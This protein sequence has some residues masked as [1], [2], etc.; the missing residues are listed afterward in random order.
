MSRTLRSLALLALTTSPS[1]AQDPPKPATQ[2]KK[3]ALA[4][5]GE[6]AFRWI[7]RD[8]KEGITDSRKHRT[9]C[10]SCPADHDGFAHKQ[11]VG[12]ADH[13]VGIKQGSGIRTRYTI[14]LTLDTDGVQKLA[15]AATR[16]ETFSLGVFVD[17]KF[18]GV[19]AREETAK[20]PL[21]IQ[22]PTA[23][24][25]ARLYNAAGGPKLNPPTVVGRFRFD[26][27][28]DSSG[29]NAEV[30]AKKAAL[31]DG[32][33]YV[34]GKFGKATFRDQTGPYSIRAPEMKSDRFT[35]AMRFQA[36]RIR[37]P[38][39]HTILSGGARRRW[40]RLSNS[41]DGQLQI[42]VNGGSRTYK[43]DFKLKSKQWYSV[44]CQFD[45]AANALV[46]Q[47]DGK[48]LDGI[49]LPNGGIRIAAQEDRVWT[50]A[51]TSGSGSVFHGLVDE[52]VIYDGTF[53]PGNV[54]TDLLSPPDAK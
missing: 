23:A 48:Q 45:L 18:T 30:K 54:P 22:L 39:Y 14:E 19:M 12:V 34:N 32:S 53:W 27:L 11:A 6:I 33:L 49:K 16:A 41:R 25:V 20:Q 31:R 42:S 50:F 35:I 40:F 52:L 29:Q 24:E 13:I 46:V 47:V 17:G 1:L 2:A 5:A 8:H 9:I 15:Q 10:P 51:S 44:V 3:R 36:L 26:D 38:A 21:V 28:A 4:S 43:T 7:E 37:D